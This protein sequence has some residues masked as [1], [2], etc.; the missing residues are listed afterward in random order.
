MNLIIQ[1]RN[2]ETRLYHK[3]MCIMKR[4]K[5]TCTHLLLHPFN[6]LSLIIILL[7]CHFWS[8]CLAPW[9]Q[10]PTAYSSAP[11]MTWVPPSKIYKIR[12]R[13][14]QDEVSQ[15][16][17]LTLLSDSSNSYILKRIWKLKSNVYVMTKN[18]KVLDIVLCL[19]LKWDP[20]NKSHCCLSLVLYIS[21]I[22]PNNGT[23]N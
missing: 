18:F 20:Q 7:A 2:F 23:F 3:K 1:V 10:N 6:F 19:S 9:E 15:K 17:S 5:R 12:F 13:P 16:I 11:H 4:R 8:C 21:L 22:R 14:I